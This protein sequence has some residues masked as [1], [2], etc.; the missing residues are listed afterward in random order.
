MM[1]PSEI[2][3]TT[4]VQG[5]KKVARPMMEK[6]VLGFLGGA[7]ISFGYLLYIRVIA[8]VAHDWGSFS[9]FIGAAVF[10]VGLIC[11]LLGGGELITSNMTAVTASFLDKKVKLSALI[12]NWIWITIFNI[13]GAVFVAYFFG[14][15]VGLVSDGAYKIE[16]MNLA[17]AKLATNPLQ[18]F[19]SGIGCNWFVGLA[20]WMCYGAKDAAGKILAIWFPIMAFVA[21]GLQHSVANAFLLPAAVFENGVTWIQAIDNFGIVFLGNIVGGAIFVAAFYYL[22]YKRQM[23]ETSK[24]A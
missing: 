23:Q 17:H 11:I 12:Q 4:I 3:A 5:Q 6:A 7:L 21:I 13:I 2:L 18:T 16:L 24:N 1:N 19:I 9:S 15:I 22:G 14:H 8:S 20:M 10:P